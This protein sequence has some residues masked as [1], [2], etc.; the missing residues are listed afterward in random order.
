MAK[1]TFREWLEKKYGIEGADLTD[2]Y[3]ADPEACNEL[4]DEYYNEDWEIV[5]EED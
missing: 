3:E 5:I 2:M 4:E 1:M